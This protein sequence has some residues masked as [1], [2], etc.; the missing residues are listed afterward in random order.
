MNIISRRDI[1]NCLLVDFSEEGVLLS[2]SKETKL[3]EAERVF[4][5]NS[6]KPYFS[7]IN[8]IYTFLR[9]ND[10]IDTLFIIGKSVKNFSYIKKIFS[11]ERIQRVCITFNR[12]RFNYSF[13]N[14]LYSIPL[15]EEYFL[16]L[17]QSNLFEY[18]L[19]TLVETDRLYVFIEKN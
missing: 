10:Y 19:Y 15:N 18:N 9:S 14:T 4:S 1:K 11:I 5:S 2:V 7:T 17:L 16:D 6:D 8:A 3:M 12:K 13:F